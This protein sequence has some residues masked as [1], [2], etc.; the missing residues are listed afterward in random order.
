MTYR[1]IDMPV[2]QGIQAYQ[3]AIQKMVLQL[4]AHPEIKAIYRIGGVSSPG[5]SDIDLYVVFHDGSRYL[6]NPVKSLTGTDRYLF[7]HNLFGTAEKLAIQME[8]FTFFGS[9]YP[10][11]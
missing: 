2:P 5:I 11:H 7:T 3:A 1:F 9:L 8:P 6:E 4:S 10:P